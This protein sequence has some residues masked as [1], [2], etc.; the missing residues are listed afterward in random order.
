[1]LYVSARKCLHSQQNFQM[2]RT[3]FYR[4]AWKLIQHS[5]QVLWYCENIH[6]AHNR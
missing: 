6:F 2:Q 1:M 5:E 4:D 3:H